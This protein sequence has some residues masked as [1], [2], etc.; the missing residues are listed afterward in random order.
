MSYPVTPPRR[1]A[2][3]PAPYPNRRES[4]EPLLYRVDVEDVQESTSPERVARGSSSPG[5]ALRELSRTEWRYLA[6]HGTS[7]FETP[8]RPRQRSR[9]K[10]PSPR[11]LAVSPWLKFEAYVPTPP[12]PPP[13]SPPPAPRQRAQPA[14]GLFPGGLGA[15]GARFQEGIDACTSTLRRVASTSGLATGPSSPPSPHARR[16]SQTVPVM[17]RKA[18]QVHKIPIPSIIHPPRLRGLGSMSSKKS[19]KKVS[20]ETKARALRHRE[21]PSPHVLESPFHLRN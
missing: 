7:G 9:A 18:Y 10:Q 16:V 15:V 12:L 8:R 5:E 11:T 17:R 14:A 13:A 20:P 6:S 3:R 2:K 1:S 4:I 19:P 21:T